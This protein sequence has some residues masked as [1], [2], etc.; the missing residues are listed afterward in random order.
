MKLHY[1]G[2][3]N[4]DAD[5]LP[6]KEY[7]EGSVEFKEFKSSKIQGIVTNA[8]GF[9]LIIPLFIFMWFYSNLTLSQL[10]PILF[11]SSVISFVLLFPHEFLHAI[12]FKK[13]VYLYI[14][15]QGGTLFVTG[16]E[17]MSKA[18]FIFLSLLPNIVFGIIPFIIYLFF[19]NLYILGG[20]AVGCVIQGIGDYF[21]AYNA[22]IQMP[23]GSRTYL[24]G[25]KSYWYKPQ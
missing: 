6:N 8:L 21:N 25:E 3:Y 17:D 2:K 14:Y 19:P 9:I 12:C 18:R 13:D 4:G 5:T 24:Y 11:I 10:A 16:P 22:L 23:K 1:M 7:R 20:I 15:P